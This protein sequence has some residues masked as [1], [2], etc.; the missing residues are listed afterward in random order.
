MATNG[1]TTPLSLDASFDRCKELPIDKYKAQ[2]TGLAV[3]AMNLGRSDFLPS[4][5]TNAIA[6]ATITVEVPGN[7]FD[8]N[9]RIGFNNL[10][11]VFEHAPN[12][13]VEQITHG[14]LASIKGFNI[15]LRMW[16][17]EKKFDVAFA[18]DLD[19]QLTSL[20]KKVI[21]DEVAKIKNDLQNKLDAK[22]AEKRAEVEKLYNEKSEMVIGKVKEYET[23]LNEKL[24]IAESKKKEV[25]IRSDQEKK[26]QT[27]EVEKKAKDALRGIFK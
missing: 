7:H 21:G 16:K 11:L 3:N 19:E 24:A 2:L 26:K 1:G 4:K 5:I 17:N 8:S 23:M 13:I 15:D 12:G 6:D 25:E 22:I 18:T 9:T 10:S 14:V 20:T 27:G